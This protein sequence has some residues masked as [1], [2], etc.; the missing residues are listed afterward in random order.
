MLAEFLT[1]NTRA[2]ILGLLFDGRRAEHYLRDIEKNIDI[3]IRAIQ[4]EVKH[5]IHLDLLRARKD[6]NRIYYSANTQHPLYIDLV[7]IVEKTVGIVGQLKEKLVDSE[8][9]SAFIF[10]SFAKGEEKSE[11]DIDLIVIG[12]IGMRK[13]TKLLSGLQE[14]FGREINPH[15]FTCEEFKNRISTSDHFVSNV[16]SEDIKP[17]IGSIDEYR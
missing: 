13:L 12:S 7:S 8:I 3:N 5:L 6:G 14:Q 10:G 4:K 16:L 9:S 1:S 2:G 11:S 17:V 15:I